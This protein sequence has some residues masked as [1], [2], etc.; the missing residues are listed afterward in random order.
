MQADVAATPQNIPLGAI[1]VALGHN[2]RKFFKASDFDRLVESIRENDLLTPILV[3]PHPT[4]EGFELIA[5]E[6]RLRAMRLLS[7]DFIPALVKDLD[8][9]DARRA[10]LIENIDRANLSVAEECVATQSHV[11]AYDGDHEAAAKA[12][13][14]GIQ[15]LKHRLRL[16][17]CAPEV[18]QALVEE[19]LTQAH[20]ELLATLPTEQQSKALPRILE[21]NVSVADLKEQLQGF[22]TPLAHAIFDREAAGCATCPYNSSCQRELFAS[23]IADAR[24]TNRTCFSQHTVAA[25]EA[26]RDT[27]REEFGTVALLTEK[28]PGSTIPL[29]KF[30]DTGVGSAAFS[31]CR[32]CKHFGAVLDDRLGATTGKVEQP[33]CFNRPCNAAKSQEYQASIASSAAVAVDSPT[34]A[35]GVAR[36]AAK[37]VKATPGAVADQYAAILQRAVANHVQ[38]DPISVLSIALY[39]LL[40]VA[41]DE[42]GRKGVEG[43]LKAL[44]IG[45]PN[46]NS[47]TGKHNRI[48]LALLSLDKVTLQQHIVSAV[49]HLFGENADEQESVFNGKLHRRALSAGIVAQHSIDLLPF[50]RIDDQFLHAHTKHAIE[51]LLLESGFTQWM[52][53]QPDGEKRLKALLS[54]S[55]QDVVKGVLSAAY[56]G[57]ATYVP[58]GL[59]AQAAGWQKL[60]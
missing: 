8:D 33:I 42:V 46:S 16:L 10:A 45:I 5:G 22:S 38:S 48:P 1:H 20:A 52:K 18:M 24:C 56:P 21:G 14:W 13:G 37:S 9:V 57:F 6:R 41:G 49:L 53:E 31:A 11:D 25:L 55:K 30:G 3:R 51:Q 4:G 26:K 39:A 29:A 36:P 34:L 28:V 44:N 60:A 58:S 40:R 15:K 12:L 17:H 43:V 32:A 54:S 35:S 50:V 27:L 23:H 47:S 7:R 2:P 59:A 19:R